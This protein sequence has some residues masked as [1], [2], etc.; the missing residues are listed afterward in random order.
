MAFEHILYSVE[1]GVALLSL[2]R[3]KS[4]NSFNESMHLEVREAFKLI[5]KD[6]QVR[7]LVIT[8][9]GRGFCAGQDLSDRN[10]DPNAES[11]DL[12]LSIERFYNPLI[13]S[14]QDLPMPVICAVN[15]V[16]AGAG[17]N[18]PLAC[19]LILASRSAKFIQAFCKI[20]LV[21]D[22]GGTWF[23]PRLVGMA[24]AKELALLGDSVDAES[25]LAMGLINRVTEDDTLREEALT[26]AKRLAAQP[27][28]G[29]AYIKRALNQSFDH[30]LH[31]HLELERDL[32]RLAGQTKD[33]REGVAAF[34]EK[35]SP[36]FKGK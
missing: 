31:A 23:L 5:R 21:P 15:G 22:S 28:Q 17:A 7:A 19:D 34:M 33:Y 11:P 29:L 10:V 16:A 6:K 4:L 14:I 24:K 26:L 9:E 30:G 1:S 32:Q 18:I 3:P 2:N 8:G 13:K 12:G 25:A 35:R 27:T 20:G 36:D